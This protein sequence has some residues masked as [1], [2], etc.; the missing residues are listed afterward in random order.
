MAGVVELDRLGRSEF[1]AVFKAHHREILNYLYRLSGGDR[2]LAEDLTQQVFLNF[3]THRESYD[4]ER[5][6]LPWLL[7]VARNAWL[8]ASRARKATIPLTDTP[9]ASAPGSSNDLQESLARA[10]GRLPEPEREAFIL[11]RYI[12]L[13]YRE[14]AELLSVSIKTVEARMSRALEVLSVELKDFLDR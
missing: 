6:P 9:G 7:T 1:T 11:S 5:P 13:K 10:L 2:T 8:N 3:W 12:G 14:I 4:R